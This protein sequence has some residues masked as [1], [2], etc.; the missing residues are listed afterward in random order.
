MSV[1]PST[2]PPRKTRYKLTSDTSYKAIKAKL[3]KS[4]E[5]EAFIRSLNHQPISQ[6]S[7]ELQAF[8]QKHPNKRK[9]VMRELMEL[10]LFIRLTHQHSLIASGDPLKKAEARKEDLGIG[11][12]WD[13]LYKDQD[14]QQS[15]LHVPAR[16]LTQINVK[17]GIVNTVDSRKTI[18]LPDIHSQDAQN[19]TVSLENTNS[20]SVQE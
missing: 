13:K 10:N 14:N 8:I 12:E 4:K 18:V 9:E 11:L 7:Q 20:E 17:I 6:D 1:E 2:T 15:P 16:L 3:K 5:T 19:I